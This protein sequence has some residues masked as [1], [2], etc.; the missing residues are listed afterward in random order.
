MTR[1]GCVLVI[2]SLHALVSAQ[3]DGLAERVMAR[4][5]SALVAGLAF[6][7]SDEHG[8]VPADG[9]ASA[10][11][12]VRPHQPGDRAI[13]ILA[14]PLNED[15]QRRAAKAM[16]QIEASIEA[17]QRRAE[18]QYERAI[19]EA[20]RT[21]RSQDVDGVTL[22]DEGVAGER[23]DADSHL[24]IDVVFNQPSYQLAIVSSI[25]PA[26]SRQV[27]IPGATV[28]A[29]PA[30]VFRDDNGAERLCEA[31]TFVFLGGVTAPDVHR[32]GDDRYEVTAAATAS[33]NGTAISSVVLRLRGNEALMADLLRKGNWPSL[34]E[35][36]E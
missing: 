36:L 20:K 1:S 34:L 5:R 24:R 6:P 2:A 17:A 35:L 29:V 8:S 28:I 21:R 22:S 18:L 7:A 26:V 9:T 4:A 13:E 14:N 31:E 25:A 27:A 33:E 30:N 32:R 10:P 16:A 11:W 23:I 12:M 3:D 15:Y 19:A